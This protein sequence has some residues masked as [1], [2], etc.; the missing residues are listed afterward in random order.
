MAKR[1]REDCT[2]EIGSDVRTERDPDWNPESW[3]DPGFLWRPNVR[4][5]S[6]A[7]SKRD[8]VH[9]DRRDLETRT[10]PELWPEL[11]WVDP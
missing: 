8:D 2:C 7:L 4:R 5:E 6:T 10:D 9:T 3:A 1:V 11:S